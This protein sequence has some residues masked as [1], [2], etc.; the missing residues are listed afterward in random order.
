MIWYLQL[1]SQGT[2]IPNIPGLSTP[3][4]EHTAQNHGLQFTVVTGIE[5][6]GISCSEQ[7]HIS[8]RLDLEGCQCP[9]R[10]LGSVGEYWQ[11][12]SLG[13]RGKSQSVAFPQS[14]T[15][16]LSFNSPS[17]KKLT[18]Q[19]CGKYVSIFH[20]E[21]RQ[22]QLPLLFSHPFQLHLLPHPAWP[23]P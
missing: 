10:F 20:Q 2:R 1:H 21:C 19:A 13:G 3:G 23:H 7:F 22:G 11:L 4:A 6:A 8:G 12:C 5:T 18:K 17:L 14:L 15:I 16:P 9:R